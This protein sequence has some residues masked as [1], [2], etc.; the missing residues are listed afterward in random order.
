VPALLGINLFTGA[1]DLCARIRALGLRNVI[2]SNVQVRDAADYARDFADL[3]IADYVDAIVTS[4]EVG[5]RKPHVAMFEAALRAANCQPVNA[6]MIG[7]SETRDIEPALALGMRTIRVA[8]ETPLPEVS[9]AHAVAESL[10]QV[11]DVLSEWAV[12][13][14]AIQGYPGRQRRERAHG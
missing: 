7:D 3:G 1:V 14:S 12:A 2:V 13:G 8:I 10:Y 11:A 4:L 6:V 9:A 5:F